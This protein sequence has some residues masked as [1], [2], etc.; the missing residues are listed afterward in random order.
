MA[1][2]DEP[3]LDLFVTEPCTDLSMPASDV[4]FTVGDR[5]DDG[6]AV[7]RRVDIDHPD[8]WAASHEAN[9]RGPDIER[10]AMACAGNW[11]PGPSRDAAVSWIAAEAPYAGARGTLN[12]PYFPAGIQAS[13]G[14]RIHITRRRHHPED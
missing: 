8:L 4:R 14:G 3:V 1:D 9:G 5:H 7:R 11:E 10:E 12:R 6:L 13:P 2:F